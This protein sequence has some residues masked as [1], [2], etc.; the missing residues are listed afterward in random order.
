MKILMAVILGGVLTLVT[1]TG[2]QPKTPL[3]IEAIFGGSL[4]DPAPSQIHWSSDGRLLGFF[5]PEVNEERS[6]WILDLSK[7]E[8]TQVLSQGAAKEMAPSPE[9]ANIDERE[10]TRRNRYSVPDYVWA[11]DGQSV[12]LVSSGSLYL[13]PLASRKPVH[14]APS[15]NHVLDP[16]FSPDG[17]WISFLSG[18]DLWIVSTAGGKER[19]LTTGGSAVLLHGELDWVYRE[20]FDLRSG[21]QWSPDSGSIAFLELDE[22]AVPTYPITGQ[23]TVQAT[24]DLQ[25]YPKAGDSNPKVRVGCVDVRSGRIVWMQKSSEYVPRIDWIDNK[26]IAVQ[27]LNRAQNELELVEVNPE[28]GVTRSIL[29]EKDPYWIDISSDLTF[30][31]NGREFLWTSERSGFRHVYLYTRA[32]QLVRQ[33]TQGEWVVGEIAG[34]D[35][36]NGWVYYT[37]NQADLLGSDLF[38]IKLDG[39]GAERMTKEYGTHSINM[40]PQATALVDSWSALSQTPQIRVTDLSS[41]KEQNL[42]RHRTFE[43]FDLVAPEMKELKAPDG[44]TV[45]VLLFEPG[46]LEPGRKYPVLVYAY[47]MPGFPTIQNAWPGDRG[48]FH[49]FMVQQGFVVALVDDRSSSIPGHV[50]AVAAY[51]KLGSLAARDHS[52]AVQYIDALPFV[53]RNRIAIWGWSGGGFT[54]TYHMTHTDLFKAGIAGAPVTD[55]RL[56]DSIYTER[57]MGLPQDDPEVYDAASSVLSAAG[58]RGALLLIYATQD[59]NVHP[60][61]TIQLANALIR[62]KKQF[63]LMMYPDKTHGITGASENVHLHTLI[64]DFL[65]RTLR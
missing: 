22:S 12:L 64:H 49:Q 25:R 54:A 27:M 38:R 63:D 24:V 19:R 46:N 40:N 62:S 5:S 48:L 47:G 15:K 11:P 29:T 2:A 9:Q 45:R 57:Y 4:Y 59:D 13:Y 18:H 7:G 14:L 23:L 30:I 58:C 55:W 43:E 8:K 28:T 34:V 37:S 16:K 21:Y 53:D 50:H 33:L 1:N 41:G 44:A 42:F 3:T 52:T 39:S 26:G 6:L 65:T 32:G 17:K 35:E 51:K 20:E 61:N 56:Y 10:R 60:Q 31:S 36:R